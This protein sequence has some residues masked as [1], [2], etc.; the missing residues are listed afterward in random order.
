[1]KDLTEK[2]KKFCAYAERC[3][4]DVKHKLQRL[5]ADEDTIGKIIAQL[6]K[7]GYLDDARFARVFSHGK[8][9]NNRWGKNKIS[10][11]LM[12]RQIAEPLIIKALEDIEEQAYRQCLLFLINKKTKE[13]EGKPPGKL[14]E[15]VV[16]Y[17]LQKGFEADLVWQIIGDG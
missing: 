15:K 2:A 6:K 17:C 5:G 8:F 10:A 14:R 13:L 12:K 9:A 7:E 11:E 3:S 1:M 4:H 16:A